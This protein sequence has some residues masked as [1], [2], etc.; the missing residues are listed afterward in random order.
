LA[1]PPLFG[2]HTNNEIFGE[3]CKL[4]NPSLCSCPHPLSLL[5][6]YMIWNTLSLYPSRSCIAARLAFR[7][8]SCICNIEDTEAWNIAIRLGVLQTGIRRL[9]HE[10][11]A[12][13]SH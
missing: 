7:Q 13:S 10:R 12:C 2:T 1:V 4:R 3:K 8:C 9:L 6:S 11:G 5:P